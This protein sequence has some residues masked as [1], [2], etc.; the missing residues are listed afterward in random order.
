M[1]LTDYREEIK[2]KLTGDFLESELDD[3]TINRIIKAALRELQRYIT[4]T[5]LITIPYK[6]CIDLSN[7]DDTNSVEL[8]VSHVV[9]IYRTENLSG[10]N[11]GG[12][13]TGITDPMQVAQWQLV[14]GLGNITNFQDAV[15]NYS[16]WTTLEQIRNTLSTDLSYRF[17]DYTKKLY[18]NVAEGTPKN[19]TVEYIPTIKDV[20]E[21][22]SNYWID[23]LMRL[24]VALTKVTIGRIRTRYTQS[25][26]LW[27]QDG[28]TILSEGNTELTEIREMLL[29]NSELCYP[30]D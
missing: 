8:D 5:R 6:P 19:I 13:Q 22:T 21:I 28:D 15:W 12:I 24:S 7:P 23:M 11:S 4:S 17:D 26:A 29:N 16:S 27:Q 20:S 25:N 1:N 30:I 9:M 10:I 2:L 18:I 3:T 14:S